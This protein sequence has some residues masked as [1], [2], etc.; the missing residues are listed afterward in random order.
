MKQAY[1]IIKKPLISEQSLR[2]A[3]LGRYSFIVS[4]TASKDEIKEAIEGMFE[5]SV[6]KIMTNIVKGNKTKLTKKRKSVTDASYKK[7]RV[8]L[9]K[10]EKISI[11]D[12]HI[13][14]K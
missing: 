10:G 5:V 14:G 1:E 9:K 7:A 4:K 3:T 13:E 8:S 6:T 2:E 11:F 12:E